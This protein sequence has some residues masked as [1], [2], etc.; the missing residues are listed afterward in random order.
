M[1]WLWLW[2]TQNRL[3]LGSRTFYVPVVYSATPLNFSLNISEI[4]LT[5]SKQ[6]PF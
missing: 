1:G 5:Q 6:L 4:P 3:S 2:A